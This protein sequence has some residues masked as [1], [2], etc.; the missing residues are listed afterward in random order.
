MLGSIPTVL[1]NI[2]NKK[3]IENLYVTQPRIHRKEWSQ[4]PNVLNGEGI[5]FII[6]T[7][8]RPAP[9]PTQPS[10]QWV[11]AYFPGIKAAGTWKWSLTSIQLKMRGVIPPFPNMFH[12]AVLIK[13][14][15]RLYAVIVKHTDSFTFTSLQPVDNF[16]H[17]N[18]LTQITSSG[19]MSSDVS[20]PWTHLRL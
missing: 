9:G 8:S 14:W 19:V 5:F 12:G 15:I 1:I 4:L 3:E 11:S 18:G 7:A 17:N 2:K 10:I 20:C 13:Q 16:Q 6:A